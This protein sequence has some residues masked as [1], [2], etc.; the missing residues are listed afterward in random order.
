MSEHSDHTQSDTSNCSLNAES[1]GPMQLGMRDTRS[2]M[3]HINN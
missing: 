1:S 3:F 2:D